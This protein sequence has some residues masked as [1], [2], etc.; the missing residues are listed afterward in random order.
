[1]APEVVSAESSELLDEPFVVWSG[2]DAVAALSGAELRRMAQFFALGGTLLVDDED[3][4]GGTFRTSVEAVLGR[5]FPD[6]PP[7]VLPTDHVVFRTFYIVPAP[8]GRVAGTAEL[9]AIVSGG[10]ARVLLLQHDLLGALARDG[11][12]WSHAADRG[13]TGREAAVRFAVNVAMYV[14]CSNYK[15]DLVHA[16][17]LMRRRAGRAP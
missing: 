7:V 8:A 10:R 2:K 14:L 13:A 12:S 9:R 6:S 4:R 17:W 5:V 11:S 15:N 1:L 3:P 16:E